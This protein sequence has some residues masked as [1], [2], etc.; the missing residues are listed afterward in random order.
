MLSLG[1]GVEGMGVDGAN[2]EALAELLGEMDGVRHADYQLIL[3]ASRAARKN[4]N[5]NVY[6]AAKVAAAARAQSRF[7]RVVMRRLQFEIRSPRR[8]YPY[9]V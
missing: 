4:S 3:A 2:D 8:R 7:E 1:I 5:C 6:A 9:G